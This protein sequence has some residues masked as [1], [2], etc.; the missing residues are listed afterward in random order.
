MISLQLQQ[1]TRSY[2]YRT[3]FRNIS[4]VHRAGILGI[5]G[6]NGSGKS[7]LLKCMAGLLQPNNGRVIWTIEE[8]EIPPPRLKAHL[9]YAAPYISLYKELTVR[10]NL[11][12]LA[13][14]RKTVLKNETLA[15]LLDFVDLAHA[16]SQ[17]FGR[18]STGQ[19]QRARLISSIF[20]NPSVLLL[21]EPGS[22]LD[23]SGKKVIEQLA[24]MF[25]AKDK[26]LVIASNNEQELALCDRVFSVE[27]ET[28]I[29]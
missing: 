26:L 1:L 3:V 16:E 13:R 10:E 20:H 25:S 8:K 24:E 21:D 15:N 9:G 6:P 18:L 2:G 11:E 12:F 23:E 4:L 19:Q 17:P 7:T 27:R 14:L 22:N 28:L 5:A 29:R